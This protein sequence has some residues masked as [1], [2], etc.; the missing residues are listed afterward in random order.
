MRG[1]RLGPLCAARRLPLRFASGWRSY[2]TA[3]PLA[4]LPPKV[5][6]LL[7]PGHAPLYVA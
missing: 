4:T 2:G 7:A 3:K 1:A 5:P 6:V